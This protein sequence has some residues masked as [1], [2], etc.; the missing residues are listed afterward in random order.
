MA[1]QDAFMAPGAYDA[2]AEQIRRRMAYAQALTQQ[3]EQP[4]QG[5]MVSGHFVA[6]SITQHLSNLLKTYG[7]RMGMNQAEG[8]MRAL[9][10][11]RRQE[12][13][14]D[15][16]K[17]AAALRGTPE[18]TIQPTLANDDEGNPYPA[19]V[20]PASGPDLNEALRIAMSSRNPMLSSAG[21]SIMASMMPKVSEGI[22][23]NGQ[24]VDKFSGKPM[25]AQ[26]AR[27]QEGFTLAPG[28]ARFDPQGNPIAQLAK[29]PEPFTLNPGATRF[30]PTGKPVAQVAD[31]NK[32]F[33]PTGAPNANFQKF[34]L[35]KR[36]AGRPVTSVNVNTATKPM[37]TEIGKGVGEKVVSDFNGAQ[38]A[39][40]TLNNV[41]Q[42]RTGLGKA[43]LGP[44]SSV[45]VKLGQI[46]ELLGVNG[47]DSTEQLQNTRSVIQGLARQELAAAGSMKGQGQITEAERGIL[48]RAESGD[49]SELTAPELNTLLGALEKTAKYRIGLHNQNLERLRQDPNAAGVADYM[50]I[51]APAGD[52]H[53]QADAILR[54]R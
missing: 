25:G 47:K 37:M 43:I 12:G 29:Q 4:L 44:G 49:I 38:A 36:A 19:A 2:D 20:K 14:A 30:D 39:S 41:A 26:V 53:S 7:G 32:P 50:T 31:F 6:P 11:T 42:I 21:S 10:D 35:D 45:R 9:S 54:G 52:I 8:D 1:T 27:Q 15:M 34:E 13:M 48:R 33:D 17:F 22:N 16:G 28:G 46:G 51:Q 5:Q 23:I 18:Q 40:Q 3:G 24:L